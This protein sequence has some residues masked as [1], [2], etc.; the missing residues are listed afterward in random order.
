[1]QFL[2]KIVATP[3]DIPFRHVGNRNAK[4]LSSQYIPTTVYQTWETKAFGRRHVQSIDKFRNLNP[5]L[6]FLL[7]DKQERDSYMLQ[8]WADRKIYQI[9]I[10]SLFGPLSADI[11][12]YCIIYSHGGYYFDISKG[13]DSSITS[14]HSRDI[15]GLL[16]FEKNLFDGEPGPD[17][18]HLPKNLVIQWGF[19]FAPRHTILSRHIASMEDNY[20]AFAGRVF[21][22]PKAAILD[23]SGPRAFTRTVHLVARQEGMQGIAQI[24]VDF[25][26]HG[27]Y[28]MRGSGSRFLHFPSY[29]NVRNSPIMR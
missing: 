28:S 1:M 22:S 18:V 20:E 27:I 6:D 10:R 9:Y 25:D 26:S 8:H 15:S 21:E 17:N 13:L 2:Q 5:D 7:Y 4:E 29:A 24:G 12:R 3:L 23:F 16:S 14:L 19:G 11:F